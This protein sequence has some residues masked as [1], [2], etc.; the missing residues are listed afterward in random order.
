MRWSIITLRGKQDK[1]VT[2]I[3]GYSVCNSSISSVGEKLALKQ[4]YCHLSSKWREYNWQSNPDPHHQFILDLQVWIETL[5]LENHA[6]VLALD[7][8][9][10]MS[11]TSSQYMPLNSDLSNQVTNH[12]HDGYLAT[13]QPLVVY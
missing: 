11:A 8:N 3:T 4:K 5:M 1:K 6:I 7:N 12:L 10:D 2:F 9:E 13:L